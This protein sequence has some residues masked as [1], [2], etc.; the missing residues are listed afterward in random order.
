M[1][2]EVLGTF[3]GTQVDAE[4]GRVE[5]GVLDARVAHRLH[6]RGDRVDHVASGM[7]EPVNVVDVVAELEVLDLRGERRGEVRGIE[8]RDRRNPTAAFTQRLP[9]VGDRLADRRDA[10]DSR[11][12]DA[13]SHQPD[14]S[15]KGQCNKST[16]SR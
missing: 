13:T 12:D 11:D 1:N 16:R 4:P 14:P 2:L 8:V 5:A 3:T 7:L 15:R 10:A 9:H 6:R